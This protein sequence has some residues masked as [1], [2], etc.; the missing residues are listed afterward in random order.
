M[1]AELAARVVAPGGLLIAS[2]NHARLERRSF[3]QAVTK[4]LEK[5]GRQ[6]QT[7]PAVYEEP[8]LDFPHLGEGYLKI[9]VFK[10]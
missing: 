4:G 3:R 10:L 7:A 1:L 8:D 2:T 9:L 6:P 5:A